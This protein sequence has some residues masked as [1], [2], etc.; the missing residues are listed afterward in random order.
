MA[1]ENNTYEPKENDFFNFSA[2]TEHSN[3]G[4]CESIKPSPVI[5][6]VNPLISINY[7]NPTTKKTFKN[8]A[9]VN[10]ST[11]LDKVVPVAFE[12]D[13]NVIADDIT[14]SE[15]LNR[16][17]TIN[18]DVNIAFKKSANNAKKINNK[19]IS[20]MEYSSNQGS[21]GEILYIEFDDDDEHFVTIPDLSTKYLV[22][23]DDKQKDKEPP[24]AFIDEF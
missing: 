19:V 11:N 23:T 6:H 4:M 12:D 18:S 21:I 9:V 20:D 10:I 22:W 24:K 13:V 3:M 5:K 15:N 17:E 14:K 16:N 7:A 8:K 2:K 1:T